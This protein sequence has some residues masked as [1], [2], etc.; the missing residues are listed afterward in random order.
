[1]KSGS[2]SELGELL[3]WQF[4]VPFDSNISRAEVLGDG[5]SDR[6]EISTRSEPKIAVHDSAHTITTVRPNTEN[7]QGGRKSG[8]T[9]TR[10]TTSQYDRL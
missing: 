6:D 9:S 10:E 3:S 7:I 5:K 1:M 8:K 2:A 4:S